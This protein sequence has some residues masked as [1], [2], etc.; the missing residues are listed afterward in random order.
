MNDF[1]EI[2]C[3]ISCTRMLHVRKSVGCAL[4][5]CVTTLKR[6]LSCQD[7]SPRSSIEPKKSGREGEVDKQ[8]YGGSVYLFC[9][10]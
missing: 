9:R 1:P 8:P 6:K 10:S 3:K 5:G 7:K 4:L 2:K